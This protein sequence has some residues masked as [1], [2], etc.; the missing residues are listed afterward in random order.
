MHASPRNPFANSDTIG[1]AY[2]RP[3]TFDAHAPEAS[4]LAAATCESPLRASEDGAAGWTALETASD[5]D[6][7][8]DR[9]A[10]C[11]HAQAQRISADGLHAQASAENRD[12]SAGAL[13]PP[14]RP[15]EWRRVLRTIMLPLSSL[16][17]VYMVTLA[18]FPG[19]FSEDVKSVALG[20]WYPV[21]LFLVF[22]AADCASR[23]LPAPPRFA[24]L[25]S[26]ARY[27]SRCSPCSDSTYFLVCKRFLDTAC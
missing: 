24:L 19:F 16:F 25:G 2:H 21:L 22:A 11:P 18:I 14:L 8:N 5:A 6:A 13:R 26:I 17:L 12:S 23:W 1:A 15:P 7:H 3:P 27:A 20:S 10:S 4:L 9:T